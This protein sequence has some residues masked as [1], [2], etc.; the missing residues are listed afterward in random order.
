ML[1]KSEPLLLLDKNFYHH[2]KIFLASSFCWWM[3]P[4][5][6]SLKSFYSHVYS[7]NWFFTW[8]TIK[9]MWIV[10]NSTNRW[11]MVVWWWF[12][13]V[14]GYLWLLPVLV[15]LINKYLCKYKQ[16]RASKDSPSQKMFKP[17]LNW[18]STR[19]YINHIYKP[20][21]NRVK[22]RLCNF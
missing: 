12:E 6:C 11:F 17:S 22:P 4:F 15:I 14:C 3:V 9:C 18:V 20:C 8:Y 13:V 16:E 10:I 5:Q 21:L 19:Q 2:F 7:G 1:L